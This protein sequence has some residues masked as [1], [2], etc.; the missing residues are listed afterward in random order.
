[1]STTEEKDIPRLV[2]KAKLE[3]CDE[4]LNTLCEE[5]SA[6]KD[7]AHH[8]IAHAIDMIDNGEWHPS[9]VVAVKKQVFEDLE[10]ARV[11]ESVCGVFDS[12]CKISANTR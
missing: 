11:L 12:L 9:K 1:M 5:L 4:E 8:R 3:N 10:K 6:D 2:S 7:E